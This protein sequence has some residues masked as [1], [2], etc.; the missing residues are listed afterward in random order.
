MRITT[1]MLALLVL[2]SFLLGASVSDVNLFAFSYLNENET[3]TKIPFNISDTQY[4]IIN[5]SE[6]SF[7][8]QIPTDGSITVLTDKSAIRDSL[9]AYY[10]S[11]G[12]SQ[13]NFKLN[14]SYIDE[15]LSLVDSYNE[16][17]GNEWACRNLTG[18]DRFPCIDMETC[19]RACYTPVCQQ[20]KIGSGEPFL[21]MIWAFSN[22]SFSIDLNLSEFDSKLSS[23]SEFS[24]TQ[25]I[26]ELVLLLEN[27]VNNSL[28]V[29]N[30][31]M[32]D[33]QALGLC[34]PVDY[35]LTALYQA[36]ADL[37]AKRDEILPLL[38]V[39]DTADAIYNSTM[40]RISLKAQLGISAL[41]AG[42]ISN[43][44]EELSSLRMNL[45]K[46]NT[47]ELRAE[48]AEL[49]DAGS[50]DGCNSMNETQIQAAEFNYSNLTQ[51]MEEYAGRLE[52]VA[53]LRD[54]VNYTLTGMQGNLLLY[55]KLS[56]F[57]SRFSNLSAQL[58]S[59]NLSQLP[60]LETQ[61]TQ[62]NNEIENAN[63]NQAALF[64]SGIATSVFFVIFIVLVLVI[65][66]IKFTRRKKIGKK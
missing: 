48:F 61:L 7:I 11:E 35:N 8:I 4:Y 13:E 59:A 6:P 62:L 25:Q 66:A 17:R 34:I 39:N 51:Q 5:V 54:G 21:D 64:I 53:N 23:T 49:E 52:E 31:E 46:L 50:L 3:F 14:Q 19:W 30:D 2:S 12:L 57:N 33:P 41:C 38:T 44:S 26:D 65:V 40:Q 60:A 15:L 42:L 1:F 55:S 9:I 29:N 22:S 16:S 32:F 43:N 45:S 58:D 20:L 37:L 18:I 28:A 63:S 10:A 27:T 47:S 24:S 56:D 36:Q